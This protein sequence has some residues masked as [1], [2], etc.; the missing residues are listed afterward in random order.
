MAPYV[1]GL[2]THHVRGAPG[3]GGGT[4]MGTMPGSGDFARIGQCLQEKGVDLSG[5]FPNMQDPKVIQ[6]LNDCGVPMPAGG[7]PGMGMGAGA[8]WGASIRPSRR[9]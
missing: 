8:S 9:C 5:G 4:T 6:A 2:G 3:G 1:T 7:A